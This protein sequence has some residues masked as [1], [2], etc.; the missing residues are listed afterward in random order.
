MSYGEELL[1]STLTFIGLLLI[2]LTVVCYIGLTAKPWD[3]DSPYKQATKRE[4][5]NNRWKEIL[6]EPRNDV[7]LAASDTGNNR[8]HTDGV[9]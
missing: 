7:K 1:V 8:S 5:A 2:F 4:Q 6:N 3:A 9:E